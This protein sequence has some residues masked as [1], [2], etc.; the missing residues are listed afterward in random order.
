MLALADASRALWATAGTWVHVERGDYEL[1]RCHAALGDGEA[2]L[3][4]AR[5]CLTLVQAHAG[6]PEADAFETFFAH[7]AVAWAQRAAGNA[8]GLAHEQARM[9]QLLAEITDP[10]LK[11]W[12]EE[13]LAAL[14]QE[15]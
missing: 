10:G 7:E 2:A 13:A 8:E 5:A 15:G 6:E 9:R 14:Q 12:C 3:R 11:P 1:A 4:H